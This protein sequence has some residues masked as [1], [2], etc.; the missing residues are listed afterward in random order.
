MSPLIREIIVGFIGC[1][2][3][4]AAFFITLYIIFGFGGFQ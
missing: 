1:S 3:I 4:V 2:A